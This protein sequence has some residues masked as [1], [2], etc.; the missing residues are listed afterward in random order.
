MWALNLLLLREKL[1]VMSSYQLA[2]TV[3][4]SELM[5]RLWPSLFFLPQCG[6]LL[7]C[8][9]CSF[10]ST[11]RYSLCVHGRIWVQDH[12]ISKLESLPNLCV[13]VCFSCS[14]M[15]DPLWP[16]WTVARQAPLSMSSVHSCL[17]ARHG[18][19]SGF[20]SPSPGVLPNPGSNPEIKPD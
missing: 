2:V 19:W 15:S 7:V 1:Q 16:P 8:L 10:H 18:Y 5:V 20:P 12:P 14:V 4:G 13:C 17:F 6:F 11:S 3:P 9:M